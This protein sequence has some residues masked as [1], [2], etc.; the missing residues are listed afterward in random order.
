MNLAAIGEAAAQTAGDYKALV[1][2]F[3]YGGNDYANTVIP[4]DSSNYNAYQTIR[5]RLA[6]PQSS[7][8]GTALAPGV[9][10]PGG[11]QMALA[12]ELAPLKTLFDQG[13]LGV[14]LNIGTLAVPTTLAQYRAKSVPLPPKLF[15]HNDQQSY[16][17]S[18]ASGEGGSSGWG[19]RLA[20]L[21]LSSNGQSLFSAMSINGNALMLSGKSSSQYTISPSGTFGLRAAESNLFGSAACSAMLRTLVTQNRP[22]LIENAHAQTMVRSLSG[23]ASLKSA[24]AAAP[25]PS[26][27]FDSSN[28]LAGQ[29]QMV[30]RL[31]AARHTLGCETASVFC[32]VGWV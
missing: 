5:Q 18:A 8:A 22:H 9:A 6:Y 12:P 28:S 27:P 25:A 2:V 23:N 32:R 31:I 17:Q 14:V 15:S 21:M 24:L 11:R 13:N 3:L 20:D 30:A 10:L 26:T 4:F 1:C 19:G 16:W 29:L 7:L